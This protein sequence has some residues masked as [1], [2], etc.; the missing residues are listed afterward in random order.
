MKIFGLRIGGGKGD[1][2]RSVECGVKRRKYSF[3]GV[4]WEHREMDVEQWSMMQEMMFGNLNHKDTK[5][6]EKG[7]LE[8]QNIGIAKS[9]NS[10]IAE[11]VTNAECGVRSGDI[12]ARL[13]ARGMMERVLA[14][15]L[16]PEGLEFDAGRV[17][18]HAGLLRKFPAEWAM[19]VIGDFFRLN[20]CCGGIIQIYGMI[21]EVR[22]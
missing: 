3:G 8:S 12:R 19:E 14:V 22:K 2:V 7:I 15:L 20:P 21:E 11:S 6:T 4:T 16:V 10:G 1:G 9:Q 18:R 17:P 5:S 13:M